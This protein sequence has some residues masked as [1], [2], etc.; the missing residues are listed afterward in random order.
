MDV[1]QENQWVSPY[2][3]V[4]CVVF[5]IITNQLYI[6]LVKRK[7]E[8][9]SGKW[10]LPGG[11]CPTGTKTFDAMTDHM[12]AKTGIIVD[13]L[14]VLEQLYT[15]DA[16][17]VDPRGPNVIVSYLGL[18][19]NITPLASKTTENPQFFPINDLPED[20][21][22]NHREIINYAVERVRSKIT[23]TNA[24]FALL[25]KLFTFA[26][27]QSTY[28]TILGQRLDK[29]NFRKKFMSLDMIRE[30]DEY[31]REGAHRPAKLFRFNEQQLEYL[32]RSFD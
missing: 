1:M 31:L 7:R 26:Q 25:P 11:F 32:G 3:S 4:D 10:A 9:Y 6:L 21:A 19:R 27:L 28:E 22:Y 8:P 17:D 14:H 24:V 20:L 12:R 5:Q 13:K 2:V 30:T 23:Y 16:I 15:F 29:R 18:T